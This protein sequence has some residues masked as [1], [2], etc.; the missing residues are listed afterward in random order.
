VSASVEASVEASPRRPRLA[1]HFV[2]VT[3]GK[4]GVGK[5]SLVTSVGVVL[6]RAGERVLAVDLDLGLG[7]V[8]VMLRVNAR[9][10]IED[11]LA[12]ERS[13]EECIH[14]GPGGLCVLPAGSGTLAM[15]RPDAARRRR[16]LEGLAGVADRYDL[17]LADTAAGIGPDVL[18]FCAAAD[19]VLLVTAPEPA[20]VTDAYG[21]IKAL[22]ALGRE[23]G[24][25]VPTPEL[26]V[27]LCSGSE[28]AERTAARLRAV[29]ERFLARSPRLLGWLPRCAAVRDGVWS[30]VPFALS[31]GA[32]SG[33]P[34]ARATGGPAA[35]RSLAG[36]CLARLASEIRA[37]LDA[38]RALK[39]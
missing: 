3:G 27:N 6:A 5:T 31:D 21:L 12:G 34:R 17:I 20:A 33:N 16:I 29:C 37:G 9:A 11:H 4:G 23:S 1:A 22:D 15:G 2:V 13:I 10:T 8:S 30:E 25:D 32:E 7:D 38:T 35:G 19:R 36:R 26:V 18:D 28:E 39:T 24:P 14:A